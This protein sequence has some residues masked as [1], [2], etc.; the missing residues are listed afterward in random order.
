MNN[1]EDKYKPILPEEVFITVFDRK[2]TEEEL[3]TGLSSDFNGNRPS[4]NNFIDLFASVIR[5][6]GR[7]DIK[8]YARIMGVSPDH[9]NGAVHAL[10]GM[11][12]FDWRNRYLLLEAQELL[13]KTPMKLKEI[14][15]KLGFT[16]PSVFSKYFRRLTKMEPYEWRLLKTQGYKRKYHPD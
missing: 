7:R 4:G 12:A 2:P 14:S 10:G 16:Q 11:S 15:D 9:F 13:E 5:K 1:L 3:W 8:E 6:Y